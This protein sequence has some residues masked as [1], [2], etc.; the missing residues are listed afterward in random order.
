VAFVFL[1]RAEVTVRLLLLIAG[2]ASAGRSGLC[3]P[4][5]YPNYKWPTSGLT[6]IVNSSQFGTTRRDAIDQARGSWDS[7]PGSFF[8]IGRIRKLPLLVDG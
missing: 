3:F 2:L 1:R 6:L 8:T 4:N 5:F 7:V